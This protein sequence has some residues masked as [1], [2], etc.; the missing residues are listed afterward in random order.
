MKTVIDLFYKVSGSH[1]FFENTSFRI[2][3]YIYAF[4]QNILYFTAIQE[5]DRAIDKIKWEEDVEEACRDAVDNEK[6]APT[7]SEHA[8]YSY[9]AQVRRPSHLRDT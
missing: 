7:V 2:Y 9:P 1:N 4:G 8:W 3:I 6:G 5:K